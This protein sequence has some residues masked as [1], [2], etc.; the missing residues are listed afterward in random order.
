ML[1]IN[2][3]KILIFSDIHFGISRDS[4]FKMQSNIAVIDWIIETCISRKI[5]KI[6]FMGDWFDNRNSISTITMNNAYNQ[7]KKFSENN[8]ELFLIV[9]NHDTTFKNSNDINSLNIFRE[10][11]NVHIF[12]SLTELTFNNKLTGLFC[13]WQC[14][15]NIDAT[16]KYNFV[17]GHFEYGMINETADSLKTSLLTSISPLVF[18][19]HFHTREEK[20]FN[21]SSILNIGSPLEL[22]WS[23]YENQKG[24]YILDLKTR[25]YEFVENH[26]SPIHKKYYWSKLRDKSVKLSEKDIKNNYI[27]LIVDDKYNYENI[28]KINNKI[29]DM[30][31]A[32]SDV[33]FVFNFNNSM[34]SNYDAGDFSNMSSMSNID[35]VCK[36]IDTIKDMLNSSDIDP[37]EIKTLM[38]TYYNNAQGNID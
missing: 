8:I 19:G 14:W 18:S 38:R 7:F 32:K 12:H 2:A 3:S 5:D 28:I 30:K 31:A 24:V 4:M 26:I 10:I 17:F 15:N 13:P 27:K 9:G 21:S 37:E 29:L 34:N 23:D 25:E 16:K 36:Y 35:Y 20:I 11:N 22:T 1:N 6:I 33:E